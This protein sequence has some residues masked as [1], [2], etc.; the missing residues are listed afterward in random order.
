[1]N[2]SPITLYSFLSQLGR[3]YRRAKTMVIKPNKKRLSNGELRNHKEADH[4]MQPP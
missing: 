1:M 2:T 3:K 4:S